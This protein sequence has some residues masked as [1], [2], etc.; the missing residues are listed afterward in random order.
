MTLAMMTLAMTMITQEK[1]LTRG[2]GKRRTRSTQRPTMLR[3]VRL[4][5]FHSASLCTAPQ[6]SDFAT[7]HPS[8]F[9]PVQPTSRRT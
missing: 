7:M 4:D 5:I 9:A 3:N 2:G 1:A 6:P 8:T